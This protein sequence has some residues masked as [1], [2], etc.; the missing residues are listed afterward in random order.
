[1]VRG[2][3]TTGDTN[4]DAVAIL[5]HI[6]ICNRLPGFVAKLLVHLVEFQVLSQPSGILYTSL[7]S[8]ILHGTTFQKKL[9]AGALACSLNGIHVDAG[10]VL[11]YHHVD[12]GH[13]RNYQHC[14][15]V[16]STGTWTS[17]KPKASRSY[18]SMSWSNGLWPPRSG[19]ETE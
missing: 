3:F 15:R 2:I 1:M 6:E 18:L 19:P 8:G 11:L 10:V 13:A 7:G 4:H 14:T 5:D 16:S 9:V 17:S 12:E